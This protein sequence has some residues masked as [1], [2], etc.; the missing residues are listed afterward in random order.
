M[1]SLNSKTSSGATH[2]SEGRHTHAPAIGR[3]IDDCPRCVELTARDAAEAR[4]AR[5]ARAR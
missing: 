5:C 4:V 2:G 3:Y 1:T